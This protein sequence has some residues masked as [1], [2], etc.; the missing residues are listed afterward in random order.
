[1]KN[2]VHSNSTLIIPPFSLITLKGPIN[3]PIFVS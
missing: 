1:M 2:T 3:I